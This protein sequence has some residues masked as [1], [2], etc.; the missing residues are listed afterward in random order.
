MEEFPPSQASETLPDLFRKADGSHWRIFVEAGGIVGRPKL[1]RTLKKAGAMVCSDPKQAQVIL[2]DS[3]SEQG[4]QFIRDWG[5]DTDKVVLEHSWVKKSIAAGHVLDQ[6]WDNWGGCLTVDDGLPIAREESDGVLKS[7]LP[8]PRITPVEVA[9]VE[10][11][12]P[13]PSVGSTPVT[14]PPGL[15]HQPVQNAVQNGMRYTPDSDVLPQSQVPQFPPQALP[16]YMAQSQAM[17]PSFPQSANAMSGFPFAPAPAMFNYMSQYYPMAQSMFQWNAPPGQNFGQH[18]F[19]QQIA[20]PMRL[21]QYPQDF[22]P[23]PADVNVHHSPTPSYIS[24]VA[25]TNSPLSQSGI[26]PSLSRRSPFL[27]TATP[28]S[29]HTSKGNTRSVSPPSY[30]SPSSSRPATHPALDPAPTLS[31]SLFT[32]RTGTELS[33]FVQVDMSN[34]SKVVTTIKRNG[35]KIST[36][37]T[38]AD[39]AILYSRSKTFDHLLQST[40]AAGRP[41]INASFVF[42]SVEQ[43]KLLDTSPYEFEAPKTSP[44]GKR[45]GAKCLDDE[46]QVKPKRQRLEK[47]SSQTTKRQQVKIK[48]ESSP[49]KAPKSSSG[50]S[51]PS[52]EATANAK[53]GHAQ[54]LPDDTPRPRSPTPP[55]EHTRIRRGIREGFMYSD[56]EREYVRRY[57]P[58]LLQRDHRMSLTGVAHALHKK[59]DNHSFASWRAFLSGPSFITEFD[60]MRKRAGIEYRKAQSQREA[61]QATEAKETDPSGST[62]ISPPSVPSLSTVDS[63]ALRT[64]IEEEVEIVARFFALEGGNDIP[65]DD[66]EKAWAYLTEK[67][68]CKTAKSWE[69]FY[70]EYHEA[71][72]ERYNQLVDASVVETSDVAY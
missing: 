66:H 68:I 32:S 62:R 21:G 50:V 58:I 67:V 53:P 38:T 3:G 12:T 41:A 6:D 47:P 39:Y 54:T 33:F 72:R 71:V 26:P 42:D 70:E 35:G 25:S 18:F 29:L 36:N 1:I 37:N 14:V 31:S 13:V 16:A 7:P 2:V 64:K 60:L 43:Q 45:K 56:H 10:R 30:A 49:S 40:L 57:V 23:P 8:T 61:M 27:S 24:T 20:N 44:R 52:S 63:N 5:K 4:R 22:N 46:R 17:V 55:A 34:R 69:A 59:M 65:L 48:E 11:A 9:T 15:T 28:S 19:N 51:L